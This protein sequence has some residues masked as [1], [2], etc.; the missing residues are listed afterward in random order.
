MTDNKIEKL[1]TEALEEKYGALVSV[2]DIVRYTGLCRQKVMPIVS[3]CKPFG[4][5]KKKRYF[6]GEVVEN[7]MK[8][9]G[10]VPQ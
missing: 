7:L 4:D 3:R 2:A 6:A 8:I 10:G 1:M 5:T 9:E